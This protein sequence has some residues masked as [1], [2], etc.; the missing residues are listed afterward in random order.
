MN[1]AGRLGR[2]GRAAPHGRTAR[3]G[4]RAHERGLTLLEAVAF[5]GVAAVVLVGAVTLIENANAAASASR[6]V[7]QVNTIAS[8]VK[9][10]AGSATSG[11]YQEMNAGSTELMVDLVRAKVFPTTLQSETSQSGTLVVNEWGGAV[12][13]APAGGSGAPI[14]GSVGYAT[15]PR[16]VCTRAL[17]APGDW[18]EIRVNSTTVATDGAT[19]TLAEA[20]TACSS[21]DDNVMNW[22]F[23][24]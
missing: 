10:L 5:L 6:L 13:V 21:A 2:I 3:A 19:P 16:D 1:V 15:V 7:D 12:S 14:V 4:A 23:S 24:L 22:L 8:N 11:I 18:L 17:T 9:A 20:E